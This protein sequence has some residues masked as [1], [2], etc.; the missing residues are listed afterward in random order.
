ML[1]IYSF[2]IDISTKKFVSRLIKQA[3]FRSKAEFASASP[4]Y[5][6]KVLEWAKKAKAYDEL[7][8]EE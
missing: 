3:G 7:M 4:A 6:N 2:N 1:I 8:K 5:L